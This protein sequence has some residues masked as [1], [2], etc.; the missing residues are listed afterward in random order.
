MARRD[1]ESDE[2]AVVAD[3]LEAQHAEPLLLVQ[4]DGFPA[5]ET[6]GHCYWLR[7]VL[8]EARVSMRTI[9]REGMDCGS[10]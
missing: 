8:K 10:L 6:A 9:G 1:T 5:F 4:I 2:V 3:V 7:E